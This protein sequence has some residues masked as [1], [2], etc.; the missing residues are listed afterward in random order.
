MK[1]KI[2]IAALAVPLVLTIARAVTHPGVPERE[3]EG[4]PH[5][6]EAY[7]VLRRT[8]PDDPTFNAAAARFQAVQQAA[9]A[10]ALQSANA[11]TRESASISAAYLHTENWQAIGP[12]PL[13]HGET[14]WGSPQHLSA[15]SGR[16]TAIALDAQDE[17]AFIGAA[18]GGVW[19]TSDSGQTWAPIG[20]QL[21]SLAIGS[22]AI[23]PGPHPRNEATLYVG[24]GEGNF[25]CDTYGGVGVYK[26]TDSGR[27]WQG[28]Y[29][30]S[31]FT[32]RAVN[33]IAIDRTN[34][35]TLLATT[36]TA[37]VS[38]GGACI[39]EP[40]LPPRG[41]FKST[42]AGLTWTK[43]TTQVANDPA[44][45]VIQDPVTPTRWWAAMY[46]NG[47]VVG[48]ILRSDDSGAT[49]N[50]I[51]GT[52]G[53]PPLDATG[54]WSR[55]AITATGDGHGNTVL[56]VGNGQTATGAGSGGR[57]F[58]SNDSGATWTELANAQGF[59]NTQCW[60]DMPIAVEPGNPSV[61]YTGGSYISSVDANNNEV[62]PSE[63]MRSNDG[64]ATFASKVRSADGTTALHADVHAIQVWPGRSNEIW[65]A[66][67]G[68][69]WKSI[70][71]GDNWVN[72]NTNLQI[73]Q[74]EQCDL[75]QAN[76]NIAY[77]GTQ[78]NGVDGFTG[79][80]GWLHLDYG[81]GGTA[82]IDQDNPNNLVHTYYDT[83]G[84]DWSIGVGYT[85]AGFTALEN[86]SFSGAAKN[87]PP[88]NNGMN[89]TDRVL[90][91]PPI[92]LDRGVHDTL[93]FGTNKLYRADRFFSY[94]TGAPN[95][96]SALGPGTGGQDLA[97]PNGEISA[98]T[99]L[100]NPAPGLDAQ[101][102]FTGSSNGHVFVSNDS[103]ASFTEVDAAPS[104]ISLFV[105]SILIDPRHSNVVY[106]ARAGFTGSLPA[107]NVRKSTD[108][109]M[110][111]ADA[112]NGLPDIPVNA[113]VTDPIVPNAIWAGTDAG[114]FLSTDGGTTW[115][116]YNTGLPN[117][118]VYD[119]KTSRQPAQI[120]A[121]THGRGA[122]RLQFDAIF[123]DG[124][125]V[126]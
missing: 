119:L 108:G 34:P 14:P 38:A 88:Y 44:S 59:C 73:T 29:G 69:V 63:F 115:N 17:V 25:G 117:V 64:G 123:I 110:T 37:F 56:Y 43:M 86:Y 30:S 39:T 5:L 40:S 99:T 8:N 7:E 49:W 112:S 120:I 92:H 96:F 124:F 102:I 55:A 90:W 75:Y 13:L 118:P 94:P 19:R 91:Y 114:V 74:F 104:P 113:L 105:T 47:G 32:N 84:G 78:D 41:I 77:C 20:D 1:F 52:G 95:I 18:L 103:G 3:L 53:L 79:G 11:Q 100:P 101:T 54:T 67:D 35:N 42:D 81:D 116:P 85:T 83:S 61:L 111:W 72:L 122:F 70:D 76:P 16:V 65:V 62:T 26:S 36:G 58:K 107:H 82:L 45:Q 24:T 15:V 121:F 57:V 98:I 126:P 9:A 106:Q 60:Y 23:A 71:R 87:N 80:A 2:F 28:P 12:T 4:P 27:T 48:G 46:A 93:Y 89:Y 10:S 22:I 33:S 125:E 50:Q 109:G 31:L 66:N 21:G 97:L 68:G 6:R 51:A